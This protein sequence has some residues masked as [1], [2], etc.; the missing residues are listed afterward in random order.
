MDYAS[1]LREIE[2]EIN[3]N[4]T[5]GQVA[6]Y[7]PELARINPQKYGLHLACMN[8][9]DFHLGDHTEKFSIQSISKVLSLTMALSLVGEKL[10]SRVD[11]EPSGDPFNHLSLLEQENGIPRNPLINAGAIVVADVLVSE[12]KN[13]K[14][15]FLEL[16]AVPLQWGLCINLISAKSLLS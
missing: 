5:R 1:I 16:E 6:S 14:V 2:K 10:W 11:V 12:L 7:I 9:D 13:A 4:Q 8:G 15:E 3:L